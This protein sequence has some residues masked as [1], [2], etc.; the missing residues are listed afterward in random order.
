MALNHLLLFAVLVLFILLFFSPLQ[1]AARYTDGSI[2][3]ADIPQ[4]QHRGASYGHSSHMGDGKAN[5][6]DLIL[7]NRSF[8]YLRTKSAT[9]CLLQENVLDCKTVPC[10]E[11]RLLL[12]EHF[13][14]KSTKWK[15][16]E[17]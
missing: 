3:S 8:A 11:T 13:K 16:V 6:F 14:V 5:F 2:Q 12:D 15:R 1:A 7:G 9:N 17:A 4:P 10:E